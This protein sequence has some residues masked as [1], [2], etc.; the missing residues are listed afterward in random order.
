MSTTHRSLATLIGPARA[1]NSTWFACWEVCIQQDAFNCWSAQKK[2]MPISYY[3][4]KCLKPPSLIHLVS[5]TYLE[6]LWYSFLPC[7]M[8][9]KG[10]AYTYKCR[11]ISLLC[12]RR[13]RLFLPDSRLHSFC[14]STPCHSFLENIPIIWLNLILYHSQ[15]PASL[16]PSWPCSCFWQHWLCLC[17]PRLRTWLLISKWDL[18]TPW[19]TSR[20]ATHYK[21]SYIVLTDV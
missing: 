8:Y 2:E 1:R 16:F 6:P 21:H 12:C 5:A 15:W 10:I 9:I 7:C 19:T 20:Y 4:S 18:T 17:Q 13:F 3:L 14:G 11:I